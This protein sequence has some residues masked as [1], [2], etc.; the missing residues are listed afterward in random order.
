MTTGR[1]DLFRALGALCEPLDE[2][3]DKLARALGLP[4]LPSDPEYADAFLFQ[5]YP[6]ASVY[7]GV[8]G[9]LGGEAG[10]RVAGFWSALALTPPAEPDHLAA[11]LSLYATLI[12]A[13]DTATDGERRAMRRQA[14]KALLWEHLL[15]WLPAYIDKMKEIA[16]SF[17]AVWAEVLEHALVSEAAALGRP[18]DLSLHLRSSLAEVPAPGGGKQFISWLVAPVRSGLVLVRSDLKRAAADLGLGLRIGERRW[19]LESLLSQNPE[20]TL[21]WLAGE[22]H[23][24]AAL[25]RRWLPV[26]GEIARFWVDRAEAAETLITEALAEATELAVPRT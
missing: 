18:D 23:R 2:A 17:Y 22:T 8:E 26:T 9:M 25:H 11:L 3:H 14:R 10:D 5:L 19:V 16:P 20:A 4:G 6:Y 1:A 21:S 13:E 12:E 7:V 15:C 24:W